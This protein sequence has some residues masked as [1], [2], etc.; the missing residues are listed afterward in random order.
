M[1]AKADLRRRMREVRDAIPE[2]DR[3]AFS[4]RICDRAAQLVCPGETVFV[5]A[6]VGSEVHTGGLIRALWAKGCRVCLPKITGKGCMVAVEYRHG[7]TLQS[8]RFGI[9]APAAGKTV[10]PEEI[11]AAFVPGLAFDQAGNRLGYGGGYYDRWL[12]K[13]GARRIGLAYAVQRI[14]QVPAEAWDIPMDMLV[15]EADLVNFP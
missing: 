5:Y 12:A 4:R 8:D 15:T 1:N 11:S 7:D 10:P 3:Q 13:S 9:P 2:A 14:G 6:S